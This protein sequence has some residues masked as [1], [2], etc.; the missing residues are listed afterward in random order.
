M[1]ISSFETWEVKY[2]VSSSGENAHN[3]DTLLYQTLKVE[4]KNVSLV[5]FI[6]GPGAE[7]WPF[8]L[9]KLRKEST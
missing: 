8:Y 1:A 4:E 5:F 6:C 2:V 7:I 3:K 9:L